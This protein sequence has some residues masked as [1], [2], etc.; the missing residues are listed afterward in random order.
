MLYNGEYSNPTNPRWKFSSQEWIG[1]SSAGL[2]AAAISFAANSC[3]LIVH[4]F[5][6]WYRPVIVNR[7]SLRMIV[8]SCICNML[9]CASQLVT[10]RISSLSYSCRALAY[11]TTV[12]DTM[13]CMCL[14]MVGLNLLC[15]V[16][17]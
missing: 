6:S 10:D 13:A 15:L 16:S 1:I 12:S 17:L 9:Y 8:A 7:L 3:V 4:G 2:V 11:V 5:M 14:A